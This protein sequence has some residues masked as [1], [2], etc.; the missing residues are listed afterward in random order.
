M[1]VEQEWS[2]DG[3]GETEH[4]ERRNPL[5]VR[6]Q[7]FALLKSVLFMSCL[8]WPSVDDVVIGGGKVGSAI[9][10]IL[11]LLTVLLLAQTLDGSKEIKLWDQSRGQ[12][13]CY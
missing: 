5:R 7:R 10:P 2:A 6:K 11:P 13:C 8:A 12:L 9:Y 4:V 3:K 1:E